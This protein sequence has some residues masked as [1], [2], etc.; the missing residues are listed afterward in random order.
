[1]ILNNICA[2][3]MVASLLIG[4]QKM[5]LYAQNDTTILSD[6]IE[7]S[8]VSDSGYIELPDEVPELNTQMSN[9]DINELLYCIEAEASGEGMQG[10]IAVA[11]VILNRVNSDSFPDTPY[12][13]I[14]QRYQF[15]SIWSTN[16]GY[17]SDE[18]KDAL[19]YA[20]A[21]YNNIGNA[22]YF[23]NPDIA[24]SGW[25]KDAVETKKIKFVSS[26]NKHDFYE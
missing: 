4:G 23:W 22:L 3:I 1:M 8:T 6:S 5:D 16:Y 17:V 26:I 7:I 14:H 12:S 2:P 15:S 10:K 9:K 21:G 11:N 13:V 25:F 20:L 18:T 19:Y 24:T